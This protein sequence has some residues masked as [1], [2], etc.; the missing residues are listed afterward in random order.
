MAGAVTRGISRPF[1]GAVG[2]EF[3]DVAGARGD[4][5]GR[6]AE[7]G[8]SG[9]VVGEFGAEEPFVGSVLEQSPNEISHAR[10]QFAHGAI[11]THAK[12]HLDK[13]AL[14]RA[15]HAVE[16][17]EFVAALVDAHLVGQRLRVRD[18]AHIMRP[19]GRGD[20]V[21]V[22]EEDAGAGLEVGVALGL[23][24][25]DGAA[26][27]VLRGFN[28]FVVP[29]GAFDEANGEAGAAF[30]RP[31]DQV[32]QVALG[33]AQ[34]SLNDNAGVRPF[35]ELGLGEER[36]EKLEGGVFVRVALHIEIDERAEFLGAAQDRA[37]LR[38]EMG[39]RVF[40]V[41]W[42]H[43]RVECGDF[44]REVYDGEEV[45][46][47]P[48]RIGPIARLRGQSFEQFQA[49]HAVFLGFLFADDGFA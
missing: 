34:I 7:Q 29:I 8:E 18:A 16:E 49:A 33:V 48:Q 13:G 27:A 41:G 10:E 4:K 3:G 36:F 9:G 5:R 22:L 1:E 20:D 25:P 15:G 28:L 21:F 42:I 6:I 47:F 17:L 45:H 14:D 19:E 44:H 31:L 46:V 40:R 32:T 11:L 30:P 37:Q 23:L 35:V 43:L 38:R 39:D 26:P 12:A 2:F 24:Q